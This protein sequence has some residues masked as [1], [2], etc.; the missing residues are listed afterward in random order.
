MLDGWLARLLALVLALWAGSRGA[1]RDKDGDILLL[2]SQRPRLQ[3]RLDTTLRPSRRETIRLAP[4][5]VTL[6]RLR[7]GTGAGTESIVRVKGARRV[8]LALN[9]VCHLREA[10]LL[11][12]SI[13]S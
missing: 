12:R 4:L 7:R 5:A 9:D 11:Q 13:G 3:R 1:E 2:R 8:V 6:Q 10:G